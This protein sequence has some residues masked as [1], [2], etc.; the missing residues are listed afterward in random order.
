[1]AE[2]MLAGSDS[3]DVSSWPTMIVVGPDGKIIGGISGEGHRDL[4]DKVDRPPP[5]PTAARQAPLAK[6]R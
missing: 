3:F 1:M 2:R 4:L 5:L 6:S